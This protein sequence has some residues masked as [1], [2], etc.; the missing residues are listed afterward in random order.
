MIR[1]H[2]TVFRLGLAGADAVSA[3]ALFVLVSAFRFG[4]DWQAVWR[5]ADVDPFAAAA[6]YSA[7]W[8]ALLWTL[9]LYRLRA[10]WSIRTEILDVARA[11]L[12]LG[13]AAFS[14]L[15]ALKLPDVSRVYLLT[16]FLAQIGLT[17]ASRAGIRG[18]L[19]ALRD[20]GYNLRFVL[21]VGTGP[22]AQQFADRIERHRELGLRVIGHLGIGNEPLSTGRRVVLGRVD[23]IEEILHGRIVDE[24]AICLSPAYAGW[25]EPIARLCEEEGKIVRIP[26]DEV[27]VSLPGGRVEEFDRGKVLSLVHGPDRIVGLVV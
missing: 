3:I 4:D 16:L 23:E 19:R 17:V 10:R 1:R 14:T 15:F 13:L 20:R 27:P 12:L 6:A 8:V 24:V 9:G 18:L 25:I 22:Q 5:R 11:G 2:A 26:L 7:A 21:V